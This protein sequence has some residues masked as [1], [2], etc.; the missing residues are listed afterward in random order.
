[1]L[2]WAPVSAS[3]AGR[4]PIHRWYGDAV[5]L[6]ADQIA[7]ETALIIL[8]REQFLAARRLIGEFEFRPMIQNLKVDIKLVETRAKFY[9]STGRTI[10]DNGLDGLMS[11]ETGYAYNDSAGSFAD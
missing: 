8:G 1:M 10:F 11:R 2:P 3:N 7:G 6:P 5:D 9:R 4:V